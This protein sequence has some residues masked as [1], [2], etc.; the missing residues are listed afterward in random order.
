MTLQVNTE[1]FKHKINNKLIHEQTKLIPKIIV[2]S[3]LLIFKILNKIIYIYIMFIPVS[4]THLDVYKRQ[5]Q[6]SSYVT[7]SGE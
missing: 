6:A 3:K 5:V 2:F 1:I 7:E 4:Y